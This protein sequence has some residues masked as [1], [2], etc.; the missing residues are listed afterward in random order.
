MQHY[1]IDMEPFTAREPQKDLSAVRER[2][3]MAAWTRRRKRV[4]TRAGSMIAKI[5][6]CMAILAAV[7]LAEAFLLQNSDGRVV[8]TV[9]TETD[10][11]EQGDSEEDVLGRLRFVEAGGVK[12]VF[13]VSQRWDMPVSYS[14]AKNIED[15]TTLFLRAKAGDTVRLSAAGEVTAIGTDEVLGD[16]VRISHGGDLESVYYHLAD[17]CVEEGQP[18]SAKDALGKVNADGTLYLCILSDGAPV[19]PET[20]LDVEL[21]G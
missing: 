8:E 15:E 13:A 19:N 16:Y 6:I 12:S 17:I 10:Q 5:T 20:Y 1:G 9:S 21:D 11:Q 7:I 18:L 3:R 4:E 2:E 14:E